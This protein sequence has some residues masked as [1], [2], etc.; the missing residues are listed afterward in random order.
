MAVIAK[1]GRQIMILYFFFLRYDERRFDS[2]YPAKK[3]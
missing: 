2:Y 1:A 3:I